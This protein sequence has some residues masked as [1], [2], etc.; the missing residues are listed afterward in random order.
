MTRLELGERSYDVVVATDGRPSLGEFVAQRL[1]S[2]HVILVADSQ[3]QTFCGQLAGDLELD[4]MSTTSELIPSGEDSKSI[5]MATQLWTRLA[6][7]N[8]DRQT[9][10]IAVGGGALSDLAGFV[11]STYARGLPWFVVPTTLLA[12]VDAAI[13][14]KVGINLPQGKN[15]VGAIHQPLGV[16]I[17]LSVL[18]SLPDREIR[19]GLAEVVK[20]GAAQDAD[21]FAW[22]EANVDAVISRDTAALRYIVEKCCELKAKIV[23]QDE[24]E[25]NGLRWV[26]NYGHTFAHAFEAAS[27]FTGSHG[28]AVAIGMVCAQPARGDTRMDRR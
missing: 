19:S 4:G 28:E 5:L 9:A 23:T 27:G 8:A 6:A 24:R 10:I 25:Q 2:G 3:V 11:A 16:W 13:G 15:L 22:L 18:A 21:F 17:D 14:G 12:M 20:Y 1:V 7:L 26:L